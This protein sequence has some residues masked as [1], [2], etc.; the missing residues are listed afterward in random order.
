MTFRTILVHADGTEDA[1]R[2]LNM[3]FRMARRL[4]SHIKV[5][6]VRFDPKDT[7]PLLGEGMSVAMI[8]DMMDIAEKEGGTRSSQARLNFEAI[9]AEQQVKIADSPVDNGFSACWFEEVGREDDCIAAHGRL[10]DLIVSA[11]PTAESDVSTNL[12]L[13]AAI[14]E[15]GRPVLVVPPTECP[16][17]G[18][19][20]VISWNGSAQ[21][22]RAVASALP[23][24]KAAESVTSFTV[25]SGKTSGERAPELTSYLRWHGIESKAQAISGPPSTVGAK[26]IDDLMSENADLLVM[27]AYTHSRMRQMILGGVTRYILEHSPVPVLMSH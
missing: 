16:D 21:S 24:L 7:V 2:C 20:V 15:T 9:V 1:N 26:L 23:I 14:F 8:E 13:N 18:N 6:H 17:P 10:A 5:L 12:T 25:D 3:G 19:R 4:E 22:A 11:R 27:G